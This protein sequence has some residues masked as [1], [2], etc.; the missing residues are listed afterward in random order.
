MTAW[1][2]HSNHT[3]NCCSA[4]AAATSYARRFRIL[5][6]AIMLVV[7]IFICLLSIRLRGI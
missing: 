1:F 6:T 3:A 2:A 5:D 7:S 4:C